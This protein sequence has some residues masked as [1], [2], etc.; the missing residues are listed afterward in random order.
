M[1]RSQ[2]SSPFHELDERYEFQFIDG[3]LQLCS[4]QSRMA[5]LLLLRIYVLRKLIR[6]SSEEFVHG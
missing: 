3:N 1:L 5:H 6:D 2:R 4:K